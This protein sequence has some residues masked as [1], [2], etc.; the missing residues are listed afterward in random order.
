MSFV[1][2]HVHQ[3][4]EFDLKLMSCWDLA[5]KTLNSP[6]S[7]N[8]TCLYKEHFLT[9][10]IIT[11]A[12]SDELWVIQYVNWENFHPIA[13]N[14]AGHSFFYFRASN[15]GER[16]PFFK[17]SIKKFRIN[18]K[19]RS[20]SIFVAKPHRLIQARRA[21]GMRMSVQVS[22]VPKLSLSL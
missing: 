6:D 10:F 9:F 19:I 5:L 3:C 2:L 14:T 8:H 21:V 1:Q 16:F 13:L 22:A 18:S 20:S 15:P 17:Q 4:W 11:T 7:I 12:T